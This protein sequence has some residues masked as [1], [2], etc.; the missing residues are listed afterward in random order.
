MSLDL[1][2]SEIHV[3]A[4]LPLGCLTTGRFRG[5]RLGAGSGG[6]GAAT[7]LAVKRSLCVEPRDAEAQQTLG[8]TQ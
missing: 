1:F 4:V 8:F 6:S 3:S 5:W 2:D 7:G